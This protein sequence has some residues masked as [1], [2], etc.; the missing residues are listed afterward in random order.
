MKNKLHQY[1]TDLNEYF[2]P[3]KILFNSFISSFL[4]IWMD[5][6]N[7]ISQFGSDVFGKFMIIFF[8]VILLF[9]VFLNYKKLSYSLYAKDLSETDII[10][11]SV[12]I[13]LVSLLC[14]RII[15]L[16]NLNFITIILF[17]SF[18]ALFGLIFLR[19][20]RIGTDSLKEPVTSIT[21]DLR[22]I[23]NNE[24]EYE[25]NFILGEDAVE[26]D[27]LD[28][29]PIVNELKSL[30]KD[31][32]SEERLVIG[33][34]GKWGTGKSTIVNNLSNEIKD[35]DEILIID[36]FNPWVYEN[37]AAMFKGLL[38]K[39]FDRETFEISSE[40]LTRIK[41]SFFSLV[42]G[43]KFNGLQNLINETKYDEQ[44]LLKRINN[45]LNKNNRKIVL[46]IDNLDRLS[47]DKIVLIL[48]FIHNVLSG[49]ENFIIILA[50]DQEELND[51]LLSENISKKYLSK[52]IQ[53]RIILPVPNKSTIVR[54]SYLSLS[55]ILKGFNIEYSETEL[56]FI[57]N[58]LVNQGLELRELKRIINSIILPLRKFTTHKYFTDYFILELIKY[59]DYDLYLEMYENPDMF[60]T[61]DS[62]DYAWDKAKQN[63]ENKE[64]FD[65]L[66]KKHG[67]YFSLLQLN[68][69]KVKDYL[70]GSDLNLRTSYTR[71]DP[72]YKNAHKNKRIYSADFYSM[73]FNFSLTKE[74]EIS[75]KMNEFLVSNNPSKSGTDAAIEYIYSLDIEE[76]NY[77]LMH[78]EYIGD[79]ILLE[80]RI[81]FI[82]E[83]LKNLDAVSDERPFLGIS[84]RE[85][86][87]ILISEL[88]VVIKDEKTIKSFLN[89]NLNKINDIS[90]L[91]S[92]IYWT[93][94]KEK[95]KIENDNIASIVKEHLGNII[96]KIVSNKVNIFDYDL[97]KKGNLISVYKYYLSEDKDLDELKEYLKG[98]YNKNTLYKILYEFIFSSTDGST[99]EYYVSQDF[100][101]LNDME[102][103][104]ELINQT[105]PEDEK[106]TIIKEIYFLT[107]EEI[108]TSSDMSERGVMN[109]NYRL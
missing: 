35:N 21:V 55:N 97:N 15:A 90:N 13:N 87:I 82:E 5:Y 33:I 95:V 102:M 16:Y 38:D 81:Y 3:S 1:F 106:Q 49:I 60:I 12:S 44:A 63:N 46:I 84:N 62:K 50:Y 20:L 39:V 99:Y 8:L 91:D 85:R 37:N 43:E 70:N 34:E 27:L 36:E 19:V 89:E 92:L 23:I 65:K 66:S 7:L 78:I 30:I 40:E 101:K 71:Q 31:Y 69:S 79:D 51:I 22:L 61:F 64:Y 29:E 26:Y 108:F 107:K 47:S 76:Q 14:F 59:F 93:N 2:S 98:L 42:F 105:E 58:S 109:L 32:N 94:S 18:L 24:I 72:A 45:Y 80:N 86:I 25:K 56:Q 100:E 77:S 48:S 4:L 52:L 6:K 10:L 53:K 9:L 17:F 103:I 41:K 73:Y 83:L 96:I 54:I 75:E 11:I 104:F 28:R 68:F 74:A 88:L 57:V 67:N